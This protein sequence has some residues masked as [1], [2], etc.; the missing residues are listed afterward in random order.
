MH[1]F[2][3]QYA[4]A[5]AAVDRC[6]LLQAGNAGV[7]EVVREVHE[8]RLIADGGLRAQH[9]MAQSQ[10][11]R[12]ADV[13]AGGIARQHA[14]HLLGQFGLALRFEQVLQ[15]RIGVEVI[16]DRAL[17]GAGDEHQAPGA[18]HQC[19]LDRVLDQ[20]LVDHRQHFLGAG[21]GGRKKAR[22]APGHWKHCCANCY[23]RCT[24][25]HLLTL[26]STTVI[27]G[28]VVDLAGRPHGPGTQFASTP[29]IGPILL[30]GRWADALHQCQFV[31]GPEWPVRLAVVDDGLGA[32]HPD[33]LELARQCRGIGRIDVDGACP[34]S[35]AESRKRITSAVP[36]APMPG[37]QTRLPW[38]FLRR[39]RDTSTRRQS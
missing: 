37:I 22:A 15:L 1:F 19:F 3:A 23:L 28:M 25:G 13:D 6:H 36:S 18:G 7:D 5:M 9:G 38:K 4:A 8:E 27:C 29:D 24:S 32:L 21:L 39:R 16:L 26:R 11:S 30:D 17:G 14:A 12:L 20:R 34:A 35:G 10:R 31:R 33:A 2:H